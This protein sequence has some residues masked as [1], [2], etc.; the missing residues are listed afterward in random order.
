MPT[1][2]GLSGSLWP[3]HPKPFSDELLSSWMARIA[4]A[5]G[6][7]PILFWKRQVPS[8]NFR[9]VDRQPGEAL[10]R[11]ISAKT[12][13]PLDR[14]KA[15]AV[16]TYAKLGLCR[17]ESNDDVIAFCPACLGDGDAYFRRRWRLE[18]FIVCDIHGVLLHDCCPACRSLLRLE[19]IPLDRKSLAA[20]HTCGFDVSQAEPKH[21]AGQQIGSLLALEQ[22]LACALDFPCVGDLQGE[23]PAGA[24][25]RSRMQIAAGSGNARVSESGLYQV[26]RRPAVEGVRSMRMAK[27]VRRNGDFNAGAISRLAD[28][29]Q[30]SHRAEP[31]AVFPL[32]GPEDRII[33]AGLRG[34]ETGDQFPYGSRKLNRAGATALAEHGNLAVV[35]IGLQVPPGETTQFADPD[36]GSIEKSENG[37]VARIRLQAQDTVQVGLGQNPL[38]QLV[39]DGGQTESAAHIEWQIADA[40]AKGEQRFDGGKNTIPAGR[41]QF[42]QGIGDLL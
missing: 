7:K 6:V 25:L 40:V 5:Y 30:D 18:F 9:T 34:P 10:L 20:C 1:P 15:T 38:R 21:L 27:P 4:R 28:D 29:P 17:N 13:T 19:Q 22:R 41:S 31:A 35:S 24:V 26:N 11:F 23:K 33:T 16:S 42:A 14:V 36:P 8:M 12:G 3:I 37:P 32:A 2:P 39:P